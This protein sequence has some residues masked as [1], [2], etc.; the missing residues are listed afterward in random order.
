MNYELLYIIH[1]DLESTL[2][3]V[4]SKIKNLIISFEGKIDKEEIW[5][6]KKLAYTIKRSDFGIYVLLNFSLAPEKLGKILK[7]MRLQEEIIRF[8]ITKKLE[9]KVKEETKKVQL[10]E[11]VSVPVSVKEA[12]IPAKE[13]EEIK[14][15]KK[16][17]EK[18]VVKS[19]K[20]V[21]KAAKALPEVPK[22][23]EEDRLKEIDKKL[24][25]ILGD[26][27]EK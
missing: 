26:G 27:G 6:K 21:V 18:K 16:I 11:P 23:S 12:E 17:K 19:K 14:E 9:I 22:V 24:K 3:K 10:E 8:M 13:I 7:E 15:T 25:E 20:P 1:S 5:G 2:E 4:T